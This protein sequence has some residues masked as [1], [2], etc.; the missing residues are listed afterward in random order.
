MQRKYGIFICQ[1][2]YAAET[3]QRFGLS[4]SNLVCNPIV[5]GYKMHK[6]ENGVRLNDTYFKIVGSLMYF[7]TTKPD[8]M[9][10]VTLISRFM[11]RPT[12]L[13]LQAAKRAFQ[14]ISEEL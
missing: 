9:L 12:E 2:K 4:E 8:L 10:T 3:L 5:P 11:E 14:D 1:R 7:T 13:H 6:D